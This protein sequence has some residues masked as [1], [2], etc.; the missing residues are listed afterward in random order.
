MPDIDPSIL[1]KMGDSLLHLRSNHKGKE[2][3][4][5]EIL[6]CEKEL[7]DI[8]QRLVALSHIGR[9]N[10]AADQPH[11]DCQAQPQT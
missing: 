11:P 7:V 1:E 4:L 9:S 8:Y 2:E 5:Q 10:A 3:L 6:E